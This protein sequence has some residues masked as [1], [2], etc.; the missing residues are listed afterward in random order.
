MSS[1]K[2]CP[3]CGGEAQIWMRRVSPYKPDGIIFVKCDLCG[4]TGK[5]V[6]YK[7]GYADEDW[8]STHYA[9]SAI[10]AWNSRAE[11]DD[12]E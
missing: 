10:R 5:A 11:E 4:G 7:N 3:F 6:F 8:D 1:L 9:K 2:K 12:D